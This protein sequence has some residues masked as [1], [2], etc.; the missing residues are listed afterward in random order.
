M[1]QMLQ[2][3]SHGTLSYFGQVQNYFQIDE[4]SLKKGV[5]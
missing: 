1:T 3:L 5:F 2:E 4:G